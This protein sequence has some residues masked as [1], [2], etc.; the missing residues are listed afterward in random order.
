MTGFRSHRPEELNDNS[1]SRASRDGYLQITK[2]ILFVRGHDAVVLE[3]WNARVV[4]AGGQCV[5]IVTPVVWYD[6]ARLYGSKALHD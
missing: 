1:S 3:C 6:V 4:W 2:V 5:V